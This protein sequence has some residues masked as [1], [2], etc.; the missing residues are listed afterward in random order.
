[1]GKF[2]H[3]DYA[4]NNVR[5]QA[6]DRRFGQRRLTPSRRTQASA[7]N[8]KS[9]VEASPKALDLMLSINAR[10]TWLVSRYALPHLLNSNS[11]N[12]NPHILTLGPP[13]THDTFTTN[14]STGCWPEQ[15][16]ATKSAYTL[17]KGGM[18]LVSL[19]LSAELQGKVGVNSL[20]PYTLIG[21][22]AMKV[23]SPN[24]DVEEKR[25]RSPE[26]V[27]EAAARMMEEDGRTFNGQWI[28]DELWL[29]RKHGFTDEQIRQYSLGGPDVKMEDLA[30]DL[31]ISKSLQEDVAK[32]RKGD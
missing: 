30:L 29:R 16:A 13:L 28:V 20:W 15:F 3:L 27:G 6:H 21:T 12:R 32:A 19:G 7:I 14:S 31:W 24:A 17:A 23:V 1:M 2:G 22:S 18:A 9:T 26:I 5:V 11:A 25:W 10:G 8:M 4:V